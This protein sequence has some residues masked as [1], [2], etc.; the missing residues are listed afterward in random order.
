[1]DDAPGNPRLEFY[2]TTNAAMTTWK[3]RLAVDGETG[4]TLLVPN[5]G[6]VGVGTSAPQN[7]MH[8]A[9]GS[10]LRVGRLHMSGGGGGNVGSSIG[11]NSYRDA[12]NS[13]FVFPD[14][15]H[16]AVTIEMDDT[17][18]TSRFQVWSTTNGA[19]STWQQRLSLNGETGDFAVAHNGGNAG[20]G[21]AGPVAKLHVR[22][23]VAGA[24]SAISN[25]VAVIENTAGSNADVLALSV[26]TR[27]SDGDNNFITFF[28]GGAA[29]GA[30]EGWNAIPGG[31]I[32]MNWTGADVA[33]WMPRAEGEPPMRPGEVVAVQGGRVSRRIDGAERLMVVSTAPMVLG[34]RPPEELRGQHEPVVF[35][36]RAPVRVR[37][38]VSRGDVLVA[39]VGDGVA[40]AIRPDALTL[41][42]LPR[43]VAIAWED[44][45]GH[46][47]HAV[48]GGIGLGPSRQVWSL[49]A[50]EI[51]RLSGEHPA[52]DPPTRPRLKRKR[53]E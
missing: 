33:E 17:P 47:V 6:N 3:R 53:A 13:A 42:D 26:G 18:G 25:H 34:N 40:T 44:A 20:I 9:D 21:V 5:G 51:A 48:A 22:A 28:S 7:Q 1:M 29:M 2:S 10:G 4:T 11:F 23:S 35:L 31:A 14:P 30:I 39:E 52:A 24:A 37:G 8:L 43:V 32:V 36:G 46:D 49:L 27:N 19:K 16:T 38:P 50:A 41:G 15:A 12:A 45:T